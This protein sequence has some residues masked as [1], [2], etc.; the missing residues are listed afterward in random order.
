MP[1]TTV[2]LCNPT[3]RRGRHTPFFAIIAIL[4]LMPISTASSGMGWAG[5]AVS[6]NGHGS[7]VALSPN[8]DIV[9]SAHASSIMISDAYT[10]L[11]LQTFYVD[12]FVE[13][14]QFTSDAQFLLIG[15]QS[16][17][18][19]T[20][21]TVV[22]EYTNGS[23]VRAKHTEDGINVDRISISPD[24]ATFATPTEDG[25]FV[26]WMMNSG[27]GSILDIDRQYA[28]PHIGKI[29]CLDHSTDGIHL[30]S[31]AE[32]GLIILWNRSSQLEVNR[33]EY[34]HAISDCSFT[35]DGALMSWIGGGSLYLRNHDAT[36]SYHGQ[37]DI[38][39]NATQLS[40]TPD[41][42][43][44]V[45][46]VTESGPFANR[47]IDFIDIHIL[48]IAISRTLH[49]GHNAVMF[50]HH[51]Y[52]ST[53]VIATMSHLVS[54]Y[55]ASVPF[56]SEI[57]IELDTD[58]DNIPDIHDMDDDGDGFVDELDNI[59]LAGNNCHLQPDQDFIRLFS[60]S[61]N[62]NFVNIIESIHLDSS[63]SSYIR[64][65]AANSLSTNHRVDT[66]EARNM[67]ESICDEYNEHEITTRW[68]TY[69]S[70]ENHQFNPNNVQCT[71][72]SGLYG[73]FDD[74]G[75]TRIQISWTITGSIPSPVNTPYNV[76]IQ[77]GMPS[78]S[79][80]IAQTVHAFPIH[81]RIEDVSGSMLSHEVWNRRDA[82][83]FLSI[84]P[85]PEDD[86]GDI[87]ILLNTL[88]NYWY[89]AIF[90]I[91]F[92]TGSLLY[93]IRRRNEIDFTDTEEINDDVYDD[94][95][96]QLVDDSAEWDEE[97]EAE[98]LDRKQPQPPAA[99][100]RD[101]RGS[102]TPPGAV[103][104]DL[105]RQKRDES[106]PKI[107]K[108]KKTVSSEP[109][110]SVDEDEIDFKHLISKSDDGDINDDNHDDDGMT[111]A[112]EFITSEPHEKSKK[113]RRVRRKKKD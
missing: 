51:P 84:E 67:E 8:G 7:A 26:E 6:D 88:Q 44:A 69:L 45:I 78:P 82:D 17:L 29:T 83:L 103:K 25:G 2:E 61:I 94:E 62:G 39:M 99:V 105:A 30:L 65:L 9:A 89:G 40:F 22:Y 73:T 97:M 109:I 56:E 110:D 108:V 58:Q 90:A 1:E 102:P 42:S 3:D 74:D 49:V 12:F 15:M 55:S 43:E 93:L 106:I 71:V 34:S 70:I 113:R 81:V 47:H 33:W 77:S 35:H 76:S 52:D 112:L 21:A 41:D 86:G 28:S 68:R 100:V 54:F 79:S 4:I 14:L 19:N 38:S 111:D 32:D 64:Y 101:I 11:T 10:Q 20:P 80:S 31:G 107:R 75:G 23:Y 96:E 37:F 92:V 72:D 57:P 95:W 66:V 5:A 16:T 91:I 48:P 13:S 104:R 46:L 18:P 87:A 60:I 50:S 59:C 98:Y 85:P 36:Q 24:D 27:T 53:L 63:Q